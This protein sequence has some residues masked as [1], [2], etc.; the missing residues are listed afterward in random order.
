MFWFCR[1]KFCPWKIKY[2]FVGKKS[3]FHNIF[4]KL[5]MSTQVSIVDCSQIRQQT[6]LMHNRG[7]KVDKQRHKTH[8]IIFSQSKVR[9]ACRQVKVAWSNYLYID[10]VLPP[11][12]K[13]KTRLSNIDFTQFFCQKAPF[14]DFWNQIYNAWRFQKYSTWK[15]LR[16]VLTWCL[17][18]KKVFALNK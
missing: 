9:T 6:A 10:E 1:K 5:Q 18:D 2:S 15:V 12:R 7:I 4:E 13:D 16:K 11:F 3:G 17:F 8:F 14:L